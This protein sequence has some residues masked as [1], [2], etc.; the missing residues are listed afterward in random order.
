MQSGNKSGLEF[1]AVYEKEMI[2]LISIM[3]LILKL[4]FFDHVVNLCSIRIS[5]LSINSLIAI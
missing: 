2:M 3:T 1:E 4:F 5:T